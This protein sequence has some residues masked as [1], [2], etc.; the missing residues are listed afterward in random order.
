MLL[1]KTL[2]IYV[3]SFD[4]I[5]LVYNGAN[6]YASWLSK[7]CKEVRNIIGYPGLFKPSQKFHLI[8][9]TGFEKERA[10]KL[11][12]LLEPDFLSIGNGI[13]PT[14]KNH[15][16]CMCNMKTEFETWCGSLQGIYNTSFDFSCSDIVNT[17]DTMQKL[18]SEN[19][20]HNIIIVPLNTK[21][22]TIAVGLVALRNPKVQLCYPIPELYNMEYCIPSDNF[23]IVDLKEVLY[24][25]EES[26]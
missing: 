15:Q 8:I 10:T 22:S 6:E 23:T 1:I 9:L 11:V 7:G 5:K 12:E 24:C 14:D 26:K 18:I 3:S 4:S 21:L 25:L 19:N 17:M 2:S 13:E 20:N 16:D